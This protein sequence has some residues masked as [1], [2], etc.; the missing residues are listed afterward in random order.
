[1]EHSLPP[2][3]AE[4]VANHVAGCSH[5]QLQVQQL[6]ALTADLDAD[7]P[8][9]PRTALRANF[10]AMLEQQKSELNPKPVAAPARPE[11]KVVSMWPAAMASTWM[12]VAAALVLIV[13]GVLLGR[14]LPGRAGS[15]ENLAANEQPRGSAP[16][17]QLATALAGTA[18][19]PVSASDRIELVNSSGRK[20]EPGDPTVQVLIN[21]L[22]F[23]PSPN[24]RLAACEALFQLR[25]DPRVGEAFVHSLPIQTDPNVQITLIELLVALRD[26]R[27]VTS[28]ERLARRRDA[29]PVVRDQA[30]A[31]LGR[32][33]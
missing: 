1:V 24:V 18:R 3:S 20:L 12:R 29:L 32:L 21:T 8:E 16:T 33:I 30:K 19:Q 27:A 4:Q 26:P 23:D 11:A 7:L 9:T 13:G 22:N 31:G 25:D 10:M 28:L 5:C 6:R 15:G 14:N 17:Q 2:T